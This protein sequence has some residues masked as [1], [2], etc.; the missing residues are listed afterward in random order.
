[1][2]DG[3]AGRAMRM[4]GDVLD[5]KPTDDE[6]KEKLIAELKTRGNAAFKIGNFPEADAL[7][8]KALEVDTTLHVFYGNRSA[9]RLRMN[10]HKEA[11]A[12]AESAIAANGEWAKGYFRKGQALTAMKQHSDAYQAFLKVLEIDP[13]NVGGLKESKKA[14]IAAEQQEAEGSCPD[15]DEKKPS[16]LPDLKSKV[17]KPVTKAPTKD[18]VKDQGSAGDKKIRGYQVLADG[19]K[20]TFFHNEL[21]EEEKNLIGDIAPKKVEAAEKVEMKTTGL[22]AWNQAGTHESK[23]CTAWAKNRWKELFEDQTFELSGHDDF[24]NVFIIDSVEEVTGDAEIT[25]AR[26][27]VKFLFDLSLKTKWTVSLDGEEF[28]G[29]LVVKDLQPDVEDDGSD[30]P[31]ELTFTGDVSDKGR[32]TVKTF[33]R[34]SMPLE[35]K[36]IVDAFIEEYKQQGRS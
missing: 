25:A 30:I 33:V 26:G 35:V 18:V 19:R 20:T 22:S 34:K 32:T 11:L 4:H 9:V 15:L 2:H 28:K 24:P 1:M 12:D 5:A 14:K 7:Y 29:E 21:T 16:S 27:K 23:N 3:G 13:K 8:S 36:K 10:K 31:L 6:S 17:N